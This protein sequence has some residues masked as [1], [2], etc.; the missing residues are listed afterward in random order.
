MPTRPLWRV[1]VLLF[2][3]LTLQTQAS[4]ILREAI[5]DVKFSSI[6]GVIAKSSG[7]VL[8]EPGTLQT[9]NDGLADIRCDGI[10]LRLGGNS[11]VNLLDGEQFQLAKGNFAFANIPGKKAFLVLVNGEPVLIH[12][13]TGF[14]QVGG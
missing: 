11:S 9:G 1:S 13:R 7:A 3:A 4:V 10:T 8:G 5:H 14:I 12:G 6:G 2:G